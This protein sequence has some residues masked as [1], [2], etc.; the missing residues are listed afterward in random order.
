MITLTS[1]GCRSSASPKFSGFT[2]RVI[3]RL[4]HARSERARFWP[5]LY[6]CR[7]LA[8]TLPTMQIVFQHHFR[9][10][11][12]YGPAGSAASADAG[13]ADDPARSNLLDRVG[14]HRANAGALDDDV[15]PKTEIR[16]PTRVI[17]STQGAHQVGLRS[18]FSAVEH[19]D[20]QVVR[21]QAQRRQQANRPGAGHQCRLWA[22]SRH[23]GRP[24]G[25]VPALS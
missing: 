23:V 2:R 8:F 6:Q 22:P 12:G 25:P 16:N 14:D 11:I 20:I 5:A 15:R 13:E 9:G 19:V 21:L 7:L 1:S 3:T 17:G 18:R 4:S 24:V 10:D